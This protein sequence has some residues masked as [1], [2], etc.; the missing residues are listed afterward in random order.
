MVW[1]SK[2]PSLTL[3]TGR[4]VS[5]SQEETKGVAGVSVLGELRAWAG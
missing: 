1:G 4:G 3:I 2:S 5:N